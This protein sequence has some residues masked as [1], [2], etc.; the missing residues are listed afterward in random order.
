ML[1]KHWCNWWPGRNIFVEHCRETAA[2]AEQ[3][4]KTSPVLSLNICYQQLKKIKKIIVYYCKIQI[5]TTVHH[6]NEFIRRKTL[7]PKQSHR[8]LIN[9]KIPFIPH[10]RETNRKLS[11]TPESFHNDASH[12]LT[13]QVLMLLQF[14]PLQSSF[15]SHI[16]TE[17]KMKENSL[18]HDEMQ[19]IN[20]KLIPD[21]REMCWLH[22]WSAVSAV[23][24]FGTNRRQ[25]KSKQ[26]KYFPMKQRTRC[27]LRNSFFYSTQGRPPTV[28]R[29]HYGHLPPCS[30][31]LE[32]WTSAAMGSVLSFPPMSC[33]K[34]SF[35]VTP[36]PPWEL[37]LRD[38]KHHY[39]I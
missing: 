26:W 30:F 24:S 37:L 39:D 23:V 6:L 28:S 1:N 11:P 29:K 18:C 2:P 38:R 13:A 14:N 8:T 32:W 16:Q 3:N 15:Q 33:L 31:T 34:F 19:Q 22:S 25:K 10:S 5:Q 7:K 20:N 9:T 27:F 35:A 12:P 17:F 36:C 21:D 4:I